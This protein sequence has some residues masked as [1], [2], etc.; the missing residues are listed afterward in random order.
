MTQIQR[1]L[2]LILLLVLATTLIYGFDTSHK[3][4]KVPV[5]QKMNGYVTPTEIPYPTIGQD[6]WM[7][8]DVQDVVI[9]GKRYH[10]LV[11]DTEEKQELGLMYVRRLDG[12]DGMIFPFPDTSIKAFWNK[13]TL[14]DLNIVWM[15]DQTVVGKEVLPSIYKT[16][17]PKTISSPAAVNTVVEL[18]IT[19]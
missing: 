7:G 11:A 2:F 5:Q 9:E 4:K 15:E 6:H 16:G 1:F 19:K 12:Y 14:I 13:N 8:Y 10:L 3:K 17:S 18:L